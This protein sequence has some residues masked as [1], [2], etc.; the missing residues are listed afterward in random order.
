MENSTNTILQTKDYVQFKI[1]KGN[2]A[3]D[4]GHVSKLMKAIR[5]KNLLS[6]NPIIINKNYEIIDGQHRFMACQKL[7]IPVYY[8]IENDLNLSDVQR[9]NVNSKNWDINDYLDCYCAQDNVT[10]I[11]FKH[12]ITKWKINASVGLLILNPSNSGSRGFIMFKNGNMTHLK[13]PLEANRLMSFAYDY[14]PYFTKYFKTKSLMGAVLKVLRM[15]EYNHHQML[16]KLKLNPTWC[17][18]C[19][20]AKEYLVLLEKIYNYKQHEKNILRFI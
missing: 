8:K 9:L 12:F 15:E 7:D 19:N 18:R 20:T 1:L 14:E 11:A 16:E 10:Y 6:L 3:V 4:L 13:S 17:V 2:R 5:E